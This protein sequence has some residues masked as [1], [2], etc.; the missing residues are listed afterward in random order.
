MAV[1]FRNNNRRFDGEILLQ[2]VA[3]QFHA[4][5]FIHNADVR[6][7]DLPEVLA[8]LGGIVD[9]HGEV[10]FLHVCRNRGKVNENRLVVALPSA[11]SVVAAVP[12]RAGWISR[13]AVKHE[14]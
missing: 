5:G 1:D 8:A 7:A 6:I 12:H 14:V 9:G 2:I 3:N 4:C 10:N 11:G 13:V